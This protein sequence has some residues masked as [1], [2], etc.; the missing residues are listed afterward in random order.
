MFAILA[1]SLIN[2]PIITI[3]ANWFYFD[4]LIG[5]SIHFF[6]IQLFHTPLS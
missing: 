3:V 6:H 4:L 2:Q 5:Q 1:E